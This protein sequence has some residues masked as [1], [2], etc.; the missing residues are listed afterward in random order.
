M[1]M[2]LKGDCGH[3]R[4]YHHR[5]FLHL[6]IDRGGVDIVIITHIYSL[7]MHIRNH[8]QFLW[9]ERINSYRSPTGM[10]DQSLESDSGPE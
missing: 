5:N 3:H 10:V 9:G 2:S 7:S 1:R 8:N 6:F 4:R